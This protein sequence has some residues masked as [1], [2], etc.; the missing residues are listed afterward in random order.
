MVVDI[1]EDFRD[2]IP[3]AL[4]VAGEDPVDRLKTAFRACCLVVDAKRAA[5]NLTYRESKTLS[6]E[7]LSQIMA[8]EVETAEPLREVYRDGVAEGVFL[9]IDPRLVAHNLLLTAHGWALKHWNLSDW[10]TLDQYIDRSLP[11]CW[12]R[13]RST[14]PQ[15][16]RR[17]NGAELLAPS[18]DYRGGTS[19]EGTRP[20]K[21]LRACPSEHPES[22]FRIAR[23]LHV[24]ARNCPRCSI[25][26]GQ[27]LALVA[28]LDR[29]VDF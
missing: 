5:V 11:C 24:S 2:E 1:L 15:V 16:R 25:T 18:T 28:Q 4:A 6:P 23:K 26:A 19:P 27:E 3:K 9:D 20:R 17:T 14:H 12:H 10:L 13:S 29:A 8:L 21:L 22:L 7:G